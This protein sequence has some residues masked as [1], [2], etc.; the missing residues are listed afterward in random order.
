MTAT[1]IAA[2]RAGSLRRVQC[3]ITFTSIT[4]S[5]HAADDAGP[6]CGWCSSERSTTPARRP[7]TTSSAR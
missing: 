2:A 7:C 1:C 6:G 3:D 4:V 5:G